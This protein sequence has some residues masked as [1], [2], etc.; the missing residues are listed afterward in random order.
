MFIYKLIYI[1]K[2][3]S[4]LWSSKSEK[5][6]FFLNTCTYIIK[7][8]FKNYSNK[9]WKVTKLKYSFPLNFENQTPNSK[10]D[11]KHFAEFMFHSI[12]YIISENIG[13]YNNL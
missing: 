6:I 12:K 11:I 2:L 10:G 9:E 3:R 13:L 4:F 5:S 1:K 8:T 7:S